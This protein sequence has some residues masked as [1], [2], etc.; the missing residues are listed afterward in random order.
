MIKIDYDKYSALVG[1]TYYKKKGKVVNVVGLTIESAGP[2][3]KLGDLCKIYPVDKDAQPIL[4]EVVGFKDRKTLLMPYEVTEGIGLGS[5]VENQGSPLMV[6]V[7]EELLGKT[8]DGLGRRLDGQQFQGKMTVCPVEAPP[9]DAMSREIIDEVLTLGVKAVDGLL[10][11]GKGQRIGIFAGSG[12]GKSTLMGMFARNTKADINVIA[13]IGERGREVREFIERDL[14]EE[15]MR[16]SVVVVATSDKPALERNKAAKTATAI[17]EYFRNQGKDVLLMM[18][19]LTRFSM[20]QRE[21]GLAS[22]EP[23]VTRGYPPSVYSEMPKLL[24]RAGRADKG[25]ITGLYTVLVDGDDF[26]EPITDTARSIL[27][28]HIMLSRKLGHKNHYPAIDIL[29]SISRCMSSIVTK[30]HKA[31][32][33]K[34]KN[35]LATYTEAEDLINIGA[36]KKGSNP[37]IDYAIEKIDSVNNFLMQDVD[38]KYDFETSVSLMKELF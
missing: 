18:D 7:G 32:A 35:V 13:L 36:Y 14:G 37:N 15:G 8:L 38:S 12:V 22:G 29:Q 28:G 21:I 31:V 10:T 11:V 25:S 6:A 33:G 27:D 17:A 5:V 20:A 4:S 3:A 26:N 1:K 16:R 2:D 23:P 24:E 30:E 34:L 9:P 19:S